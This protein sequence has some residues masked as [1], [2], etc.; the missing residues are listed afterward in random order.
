MAKAKNCDWNLQPKFVNGPNL[1]GIVSVILSKCMAL[2]SPVHMWL[3]E[4]ALCQRHGTQYLSFSAFSPSSNQNQSR[5]SPWVNHAAPLPPPLTQRNISW[6]DGDAGRF[7]WTSTI[8]SLC[9]QPVF[10]TRHITVKYL[11]LAVYHLY[12]SQRRV[13]VGSLSGHAE[14]TDGWS[15]EQT[16]VCKCKVL[17]VN[18]YCQWIFVYS[19]QHLK[20]PLPC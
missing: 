15:F 8:E 17:T 20:T 5:V 11:Q 1:S 3:P 4:C 9:S 2:Q 10:V 14:R 19:C 13:R 7:S 12:R 6:T 16:S 18:H